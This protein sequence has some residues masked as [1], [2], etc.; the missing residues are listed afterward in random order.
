MLFMV[1]ESY[2]NGDPRPVYRRLRDRGRGIPTGL[3]YVS[4]WVTS[5]LGT[6]YQLME[7]D[8]EDAFAPWTA[9]WSDLVEFT[10]TP[11]VTSQDA[12]ALVAGEL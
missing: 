8:S 10:I 7:A 3:R 1:V 4:S 12:Q 5:D 6:C 2:R 11:V 9:E